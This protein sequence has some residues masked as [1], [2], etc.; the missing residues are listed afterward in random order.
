MTIRLKF[1]KHVNPI[2][3]FWYINCYSLESMLQLKTHSNFVILSSTTNKRPVVQQNRSETILET[4]NVTCK[5]SFTGSSV[6]LKTS[7]RFN[8]RNKIYTVVIF[9][10]LSL[11]NILK[12]VHDRW[13]FPTI[14]EIIFSL[15]NIVKIS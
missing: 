11:L 14:L 12:H 2:K 9:S 10:Y 4:R 8:N 3:S 1:L 7:Q 13:K 15:T 6:S 5:S